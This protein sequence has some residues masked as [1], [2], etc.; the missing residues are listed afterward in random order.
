LLVLLAR[1]CFS[2]FLVILSILS[3]LSNKGD[4]ASEYSTRLWTV[5]NGLT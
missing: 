2:L 1:P 5:Q 3:I 4:S